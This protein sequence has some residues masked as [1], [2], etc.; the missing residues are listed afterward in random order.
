MVVRKDPRGTS[1][2]FAI[3]S[4]I[5]RR[6]MQRHLWKPG[7]HSIGPMGLTKA[8]LRKIKWAMWGLCAWTGAWG[9]CSARHHSTPTCVTWLHVHL[10]DM[11]VFPHE[12]IIA[13]HNVGQTAHAARTSQQRNSSDYSVGSC[14]VEQ[15]P[16][17]KAAQFPNK[18]LLAPQIPR[19]ASLQKRVR[20]QDYE[21]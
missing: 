17:T 7:Q 4:W 8:G 20:A 2:G 21:D 11:G 12:D 5:T 16:A 6:A 13:L 9:I 19:P 14:N 10:A 1:V 15:F 18:E 3:R